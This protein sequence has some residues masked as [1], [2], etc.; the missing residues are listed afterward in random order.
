MTFDDQRSLQ[1]AEGWLELGDWRSAED[2]LAQISPDNRNH[3]D[4]LN[5][6]WSI[7]ARA[8]DWHACVE[9][10]AVLK[11]L[12]PELEVSWIHHAYALHELKRTGEAWESLLPAAKKFPAA[13]TVFYNL[14]CYACQ[15]GRLD[16]ARTLLDKAFTLGDANR[17]RRDA[18]KDPDL[19]P[20]KLRDS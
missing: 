1:A 12:A 6:R 9:I 4:V 8:R 14:A 15:L 19:L 5:L 20:L 18:A 10:G 16:E 17:M 11:R 3:P 13:P 7:Q 2:E